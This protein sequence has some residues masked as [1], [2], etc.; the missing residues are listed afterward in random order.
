[1][2]ISPT[3]SIITEPQLLMVTT[4][5]QNQLQGFFL[6][7]YF[8]IMMEVLQCEEYCKVLLIMHKKVT[9]L[10]QFRIGKNISDCAK[11]NVHY[12]PLY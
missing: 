7:F 2:R 9:G 8:L 11:D 3:F 12:L 5:P 4:E 10:R 6:F 1:M